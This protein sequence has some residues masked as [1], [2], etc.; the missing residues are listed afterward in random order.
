MA[1]LEEK[2]VLVKKKAIEEFKS[3]DDFQEAVV[4]L[5]SS[6]FGEGFKDTQLTII[7]TLA[8]TLMYM[9]RKLLEEEVEAEEKENKEKGGEEQ[10]KDEE[11]GDTI[12]FSP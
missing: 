12:P 11:K 5:A 2:E 6:Y 1:K 10:E 4:T 3:S 8:L 7:P 9:D